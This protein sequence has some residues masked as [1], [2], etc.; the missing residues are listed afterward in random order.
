MIIHK[1]INITEENFQNYSL[2]IQNIPKLLN[3]SLQDLTENQRQL[4]DNLQI[5]FEKVYHKS[6]CTLLL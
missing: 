3:I 1:L 2:N 5:E 6:Y 4:I